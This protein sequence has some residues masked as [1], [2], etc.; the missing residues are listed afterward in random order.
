MKIDHDAPDL[1]GPCACDECTYLRGQVAEITARDAP[2]VIM[3]R[4]E[5][6]AR[7]EALEAANA[8]L[9]D[10]V[11]ELSRWIARVDGLASDLRR[12]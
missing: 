7:I 4:A 2:I 10:R 11:N 9:T 3:E 8:A 5:F 12:C 6:R 1:H